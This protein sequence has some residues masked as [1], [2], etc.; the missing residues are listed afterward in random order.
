MNLL[1]KLKAL[2]VVNR[3]VGV[4]EEA[5]VKSGWKTTEF[6]MTVATNL[7]AVVG[8]LKGIVPEKVAAI[9]VAVATCVYTVARALTKATAP[10]TTTTGT[11]QP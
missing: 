1:Q 6:W 3:A 11:T 7:T 5:N 2:I 8:A 9:A 10:T 4:I